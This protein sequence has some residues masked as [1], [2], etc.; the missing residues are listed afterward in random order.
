VT[1][2]GGIAIEQVV[3][4]NGKLVPR[5]EARVSAFDLGFLYGYALFETM[6][7]YSGR[8]FR[9]RDHLNRLSRSARVI[10]IPLDASTLERACHDTLEAN[11]LADARIRLT[12]SIGEGEGTP[13]APAH[14]RPTVLIA[15]T[16]YTPPPPEKYRDGFRAIVSSVRQNS[17]SPLS[18]LKSANYLNN[19]LARRQAREAGADEAL[20]V[21]E[22]GLLC[23]GSTSNIFLV[24]GGALITP[25]EESGCLPGVTRQ[26][27]IELAARMGMAVSQRE[28]GLEE[29]VQADECFITNSLIELMPLREVDGRHVGLK[30]KGEVTTRLMAAYKE[31][32]TRETK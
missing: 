20:L 17:R 27:V 16:S 1:D 30:G 31:L 26:A 29:L 8:I 32:V 19:L 24:S 2:G 4:L 12:V 14:P 3:F 13:D 6:R 11:R 28:V 5:T 18:R 23:E 9:L 15:A 22:R 25:D 7:A 21:N 10:G